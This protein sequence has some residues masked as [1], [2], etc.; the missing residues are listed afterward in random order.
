MD[1]VERHRITKQVY[2]DA[3]NRFLRSSHIDP[4]GEGFSGGWNAA[5]TFVGSLMETPGADGRFCAHHPDD[6]A[7]TAECYDL[8][9]LLFERSGDG[10]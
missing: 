8:L 4:M 10:A 1:K 2:D 5:L 9:A 7:H 6:P 3:Y